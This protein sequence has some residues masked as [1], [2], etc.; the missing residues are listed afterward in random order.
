[1]VKTYKLKVEREKYSSNIRRGYKFTNVENLYL[2]MLKIYF[3][4]SMLNIPD[5]YPLLIF[6]SYC[7]GR[8]KM[9]ISKKFSGK[10]AIG[11]QRYR[12]IDYSKDNALFKRNLKKCKVS[13]D[14]FK[15]TQGKFKSIIKEYLKK[16]NITC[17]FWPEIVSL[18]SNSIEENECSESLLDPSNS[19]EDNK[20]P[21][22]TTPLTSDNNECVELKKPLTNDDINKL[23][24][25]FH[26]LEYDSIPI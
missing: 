9:S 22:L 10:N 24:N 19:I 25:Y 14:E 2:K 13:E 6:L 23:L 4:N 7:I 8:N 3:K 11:K 16:E 18:N 12:F 5:N 15:K 1:M 20:Y 21:E 17:I 26:L